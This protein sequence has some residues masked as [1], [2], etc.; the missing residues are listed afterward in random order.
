MRDGDDLVTAVDV[1]APLAA[2]GTTVEVPTVDGPVEL[3]IPAGT[4]PHETLVVRGAGHAGAARPAHAATCA[5]SSTSMIPRHL[6]AR[7]A[8]AARAARGVADRA[9]PPHRRGRVRASSSAPSAVEPRG[10]RSACS[11]R[12]GARE[13]AELVLAELLELAPSGVEEVDARRGRGRVRGLR[14]RRASCRRCR[15]CGPRP[16][17]ALVEVS[18][19]EIA[20]DW[21]ERWRE[22]HRP[23]VLDER[24][25]VRPPW[26]PPGA[27]ADRP[28]DRSRAGVRHRRAR[29]HAAVPRADAGAR[30]RRPR[31]ARFVDLGCG[32]GVLAIAAARLGFAPVLALD[33]DP[34][35]VEATRARTRGATASSSTCAASTCAPSRVPAAARSPP[36]C[37]RRCCSSWAPRLR[38]SSARAR[39][40]ASGLLEHEADGVAAFAAGLAEAARRRGEWR[41]C[42]SDAAASVSALDRAGRRGCE[43]WPRGR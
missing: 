25:T 29:D 17:D 2:L 39:V 3:E 8:R 15:T 27:D 19:E 16:G 43:F 7:A 26:E 23:L 33:N 11:A 1:A 9:Q 18:T 32:S 21:S 35:S 14:R 36:T 6:E 40:I 42:C 28:R 37:S 30:P 10:L 20:D 24:L 13:Q 41:R 12:P 38:P 31:R 4:Q 22:F 34:A 5:W